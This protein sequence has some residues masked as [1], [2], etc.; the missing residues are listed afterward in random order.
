MSRKT[1]VTLLLII[2]SALLAVALFIAGAIWRGRVTARP[3][4]T[5]SKTFLVT[6]KL[7]AS[8]RRPSRAASGGA[9]GGVGSAWN[10][11]T[12]SR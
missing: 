10:G 8:A 5:D 12:L 1:L 7:T 11:S 6:A 2:M 3:A 9:P 4:A